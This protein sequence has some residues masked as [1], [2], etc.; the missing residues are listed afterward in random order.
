[1][2]TNGVGEGRVNMGEKGFE[3]EILGIIKKV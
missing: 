1:M 3:R 2:R